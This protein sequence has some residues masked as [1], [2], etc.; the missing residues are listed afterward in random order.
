MDTIQYVLQK[1]GLEKPTWQTVVVSASQ[2]V[3]VPAQALWNVWMKLVEWPQWSIPLHA[4]TRWTAEPSWQVGVTFEQ[5]LNLGFPLG[6][7]V[8][9]ET[10]GAIRAGEFVSWWKDEKGIKSCHVWEFMALSPDRTRVTDTEVFH[11]V[12][13]GLLK[14]LLVK[15]WQRMFEASVAGLIQQ[16][17]K[18]KS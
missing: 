15:P 18:G 16:A 12:P 17:Q 13:M 8:S 6:K 14:P 7:T 1:I 5:I 11:G 2:E 3:T 4:A 10:V 9:E